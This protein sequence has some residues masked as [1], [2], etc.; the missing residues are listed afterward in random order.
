MATW[1]LLITEPKISKAGDYKADVSWHNGKSWSEKQLKRPV[2]FQEGPCDTITCSYNKY[3]PN[4]F[5]KEIQ[6]YLPE[7]LYSKKINTHICQCL[8]N[9]SYDLA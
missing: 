8:L 9:I 5:L 3:Y 7:Q 6:E 1:V 2:S 4:L